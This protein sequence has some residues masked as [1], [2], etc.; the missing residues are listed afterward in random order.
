M[1]GARVHV[2][3]VAVPVRSK[4][5]TVAVSVL[6]VFF[7]LMNVLKTIILGESKGQKELREKEAAE[8]AAAAKEAE[9]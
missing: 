8:A 9:A 5:T 3:G 6:I 1:N 4:D 2:N 7:C